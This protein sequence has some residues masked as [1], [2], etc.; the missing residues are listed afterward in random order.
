MDVFT[1]LNVESLGR[2]RSLWGIILI[3][4]ELR[5]TPLVLI[6]SPEEPVVLLVIILCTHDRRKGLEM[7]VFPKQDFE[8]ILFSSYS[9][10]LGPGCLLF[11]YC[12]EYLVNRDVQDV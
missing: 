9:G 10:V 5:L 12:R 2:K 8:R 11:T 1:Y 3:I 4:L 6:C 7:T